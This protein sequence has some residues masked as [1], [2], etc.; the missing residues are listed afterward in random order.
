MSEKDVQKF[1]VPRDEWPEFVLGF[2]TSHKNWLLDITHFDVNDTKTVLAHNAPMKD[3]VL[4]DVGH[5]NLVVNASMDS[6][7]EVT[8][9]IENPRYII[10]EET[11]DGGHKALEII[12][13]EL[14]TTLLRFRSA[15]P[16][17]MVNGK[18]S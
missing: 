10:M 7:R 15:M 12:N 18:V 4:E 5:L 6:E 11:E 9:K 2:G 3:I 14:E 17:P 16:P 13:E 8:H 1:E